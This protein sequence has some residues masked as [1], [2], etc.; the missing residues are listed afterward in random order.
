MIF[1]KINIILNER[2]EGCIDFRIMF[3]EMII[4]SFR[5]QFFLRVMVNNELI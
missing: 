1:I 4:F 5:D 2:S 3:F